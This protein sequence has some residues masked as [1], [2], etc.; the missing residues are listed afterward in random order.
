[1][2]EVQGWFIAVGVDVLAAV[3]LLRFLLRRS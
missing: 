2:T 1:M 3:A